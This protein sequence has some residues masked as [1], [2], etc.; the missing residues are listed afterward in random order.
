MARL[1]MLYAITEQDVQALRQQKA[2][3]MY[4]YMLEQIESAYISTP[5]AC[6]LNK[7]WEGLHYC[8]NGGEWS[9]DNSTPANIIFG[10]IFLLDFNDHIITLKTPDNILQIVNYLQQHKL[11]K[12]VKDNFTKID[13]TSYSLPKDKNN[14]QFLLDWSE[15]LIPFYQT[16]LEQ[17]YYVIFTVDL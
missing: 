4:E 10:G 2:E 14:M 5:R 11:Q 8:C 15:G 3:V 7:A 13:A 16:A 1:G 6:E 12:I 17:G 9:E